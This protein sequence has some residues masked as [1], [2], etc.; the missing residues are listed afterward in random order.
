MAQGALAQIYVAMRAGTRHQPRYLP[1]IF[2]IAQG[3]AILIKGPIAPLLSGLTI[4]ALVVADRQWRWLG[5]PAA[6][7]GARHGQR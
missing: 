2:W 4:L 6:A 5:A 7:A 3:C 1:W